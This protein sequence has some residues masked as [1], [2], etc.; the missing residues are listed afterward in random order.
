MP[1]D[2]EIH[3]KRDDIVK[4]FTIHYD[5]DIGEVIHIYRYVNL[6]NIHPD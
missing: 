5:S 4:S 2:R 6:P 1:I 3:H